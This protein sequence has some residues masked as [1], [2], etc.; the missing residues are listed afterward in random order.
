VPSAFHPLPTHRE[1]AEVPQLALAEL[2]LLCGREP[3]ASVAAAKCVVRLGVAE[4]LLQ[5]ASEEAIV[6]AGPVMGPIRDWR[7]RVRVANPVDLAEPL[8]R[9]IPEGLNCGSKNEPQRTATIHERCSIGRL[10]V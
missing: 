4:Q 3:G 9:P 10:A 5:E 2:A 6:Q 1:L 7:E 8:S